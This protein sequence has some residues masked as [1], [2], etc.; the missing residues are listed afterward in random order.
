[1]DRRQICR[2]CIPGIIDGLAVEKS[3]SEYRVEAGVKFGVQV[4]ELFILCG[5]SSVFIH[6]HQEIPLAMQNLCIVSTPILDTPV[7]V[8]M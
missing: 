8:I 6:P 3:P 2:A 1:M 5:I 4:Q 7:S